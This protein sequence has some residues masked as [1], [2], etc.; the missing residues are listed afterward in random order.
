MK[1]MVRQDKRPIRKDGGKLCCIWNCLV[2]PGFTCKKDNSPLF[3]SSDFINFVGNVPRILL[4]LRNTCHCVNFVI[5][6]F[7]QGLFF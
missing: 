7:M 6:G 2:G 4:S 1:V 3:Y 5:S